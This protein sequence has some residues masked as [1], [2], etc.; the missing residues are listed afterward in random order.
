MPTIDPSSI[1]AAYPK[2]CAAFLFLKRKTGH[3]AGRTGAR[4]QKID[5]CCAV[6]KIAEQLGIWQK[7]TQSTRCCDENEKTVNDLKSCVFLGIQS[8]Q[9]RQMRAMQ[10]DESEDSANFSLENRRKT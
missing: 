9:K 7:N 5:R 3:T 4:R 8:I 10:N 2:G 1:T 6:E